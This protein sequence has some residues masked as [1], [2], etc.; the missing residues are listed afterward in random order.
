MNAPSDD[1]INEV[2]P[3]RPNQ[4]S[5]DTIHPVRRNLYM[6]NHAFVTPGVED[7][8]CWTKR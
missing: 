4:L 2:S 8:S 6:V 7:P 5:I 3:V 1:A